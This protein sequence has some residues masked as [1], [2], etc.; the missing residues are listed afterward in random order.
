VPGT[1]IKYQSRVLIPRRSPIPGPPVIGTAVARWF[2]PDGQPVYTCVLDAPTA[3]GHALMDCVE[4]QLVIL[5][6]GSEGRS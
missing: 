2:L 6:F 5:A 4:A 1:Q 3:D